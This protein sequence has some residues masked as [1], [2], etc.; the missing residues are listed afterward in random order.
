M[1]RETFSALVAKFLLLAAFLFVI[2]G[3]PSS[4]NELALRAAPTGGPKKQ[5]KRT[6]VE[7]LDAQKLARS[8]LNSSLK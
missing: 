1:L 3:H 2:L 7:P 6:C 5:I 8:S 4:A